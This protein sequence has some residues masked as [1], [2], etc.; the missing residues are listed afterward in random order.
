M[1][2]D[3]VV[4]WQLASVA[5][6]AGAEGSAKP[7]VEGYKAGALKWLE[8]AYSLILEHVFHYVMNVKPRQRDFSMIRTSLPAPIIE[9]HKISYSFYYFFIKYYLSIYTF[10]THH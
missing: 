3:P 5:W 9:Y 6:R 2:D 10:Y 7:T 1:E 8:V 4:A